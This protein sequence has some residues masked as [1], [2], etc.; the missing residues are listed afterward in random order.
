LKRWFADFDKG[1]LVAALLPLIGILPSFSAEGVIR[2]ADGILHTHRIYAMSTLLAH[3]NLWPR[4]VPYFHLG[5]GYPIF[6]FY[7]PGVFYLGG[8]LSLLG[9]SIPLAFSIVAALAWI[10]GSVGTYGLARRLLPGTGALLAAMIWSYAPSRLFEVW[11]QG[12]LPQMMAAALVPWTLWG[13]LAAAEKPTRRNVVRIALPFAGIILC[14]QPITL[15]GGLFLGPA[16]LILP[17]IHVPRDWRSLFRRWL[18]TLGGMALSVGLAAIFLIPLA[19]ELKYVRASDQ[20]S[21]VIAY[22]TS[23]FLQPSEIFAQPPAMDLTDLRFEL[24]TTLGLVGGIFGVLGIAG[25][26]RAKKYRWALGLGAAMAFALFMMVRMSLPVWEVVPF[27]AQLR[28]PERFLR[29]AVVF[30]ALIGGA[31]LW[32]L[33]RRWQTIGLALAMAVVLVGALPMVYPNQSC[34]TMKKM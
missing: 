2:T 8:L 33:P 6:N 32:L 27:M 1:F 19:A 25:L 5:Y 16:A 30:L 18:A 22:L 13:I 29:V 23:N 4:W 34:I 26:I 15:I 11:D 20:A 9:L 17:L 31:S 10:L 3:G 28:F 14:H 24:P 21:D 12:S 7:P